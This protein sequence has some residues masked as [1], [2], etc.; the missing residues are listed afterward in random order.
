MSNTSNTSNASLN[1]K[2]FTFDYEF[3]LVTFCNQDLEDGSG[4]WSGSASCLKE[5]I[6]MIDE[7]ILEDES[8][9]C[10]CLGYLESDAGSDTCG[11]C[12][13]SLLN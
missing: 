2:G 11:L 12:G 6:E 3:G 5:A 10:Q 1:Y 13:K 8:G 4:D 9:D 7:M